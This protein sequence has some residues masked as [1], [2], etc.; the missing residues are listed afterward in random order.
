MRCFDEK[1]GGFYSNSSAFRFRVHIDPPQA[2]PGQSVS[3]TTSPY[4]RTLRLKVRRTKRRQLPGF[5]YSIFLAWF[6]KNPMTKAATVFSFSICRVW[7]NRTVACRT[8]LW[9]ADP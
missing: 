9:S 2:T 6:Y 4:S 5:D 3:A 7:P 8:V 1:L